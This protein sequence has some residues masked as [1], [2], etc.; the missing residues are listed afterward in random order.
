ML[1]KIK[2]LTLELVVMYTFSFMCIN[3]NIL[4]Y[5]LCERSVSF[6]VYASKPENPKMYYTNA[7]KHILKEVSVE[8]LPSLLL[9]LK[10]VQGS[11]T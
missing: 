8:G 6:V 10:K 1:H 11:L 9:D 2:V 5:I 4:K 7:Y 3:M